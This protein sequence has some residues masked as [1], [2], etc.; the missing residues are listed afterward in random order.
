MTRDEAAKRNHERAPWAAGIVSELRDVF[1]S[2]EVLYVREGDFV[3]GRP[4]ALPWVQACP[5]PMD[6]PTKRK[7]RR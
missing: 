5:E 3:K 6:E 4:D 2:V 7:G 1:G